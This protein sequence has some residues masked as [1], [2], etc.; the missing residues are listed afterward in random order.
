MNQAE[1][2]CHAS[3]L[4]GLE[5]ILALGRGRVHRLDT[6]LPSG[7]AD[8]VRVGLDVLDGLEDT[9]GLIDAASESQVIDGRCDIGWE[10]SVPYK[11]I[12]NSKYG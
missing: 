4:D 6:R 8:L 12:R 3:A 11:I 1:A 9:L 2:S 10:L 7:G 5:V